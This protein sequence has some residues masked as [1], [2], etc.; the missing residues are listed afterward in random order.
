LIPGRFGYQKT[1]DAWFAALAIEHHATLVS[2]D[3]G[4][5]QFEADGL[6]WKY[7]AA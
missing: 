2:F 4:F 6:K 1:T 5:A 7:L 3:S